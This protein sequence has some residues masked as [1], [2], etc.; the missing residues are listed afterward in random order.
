MAF[1]KKL[2]LLDAYA[3]IFRAYYA[4]INRPIMNSKGLN[5]SAIFGFV[6][7]LDEVLRKEKPTHIA[8]AFDPPSPTFRHHMYN[9]Y[10]ANRLE[11][12]ED[13]KLAVPY[14]KKILQAYNIAILEVEGY[15]ADD[16]IGTVSKTAHADGFTVFMMTPDK[17][18]AQLVSDGIYMF[19]PRHSGNDNEIWGPAE[20]KKNFEVD[21]PEQVIDIL[22]LWGD[23]A[24]NIPG[25]P[26]IGEK[27]SKKLIAE[28]GSIENLLA[29]SARLKG[30]QKESI[31]QN[32]EQIKLS[33]ELATIDIHVPV[34]L[35]V[36]EL[37]VKE[38]NKELLKIIFNEL[39]FK[40][41]AKRIIGEDVVNQSHT[42]G[43]LFDL[44]V[45]PIKSEETAEQTYKTFNPENV[46][47]IL[48]DNEISLNNLL[49]QLNKQTAF[50][51]DT[52]TTGLKVLEDSIVGLSVCFKEKEAY[53]I[54]FT[55][56]YNASINTLAKFSKVFENE[57]I[58]KIGHNL[59][60]DCQVLNKYGIRVNGE[61]FDTMVAHYLLQPERKHKLDTLTEELL[62][63]KMI[64]IEELIGKK[65]VDQLN[66]SQID[67]N[68]VK[69]YASEDADFTFRLYNLLKKEIQDKD[70][71]RLASEIEMPLI[72]VLTDV[73][74][75]GFNI[76]T[77]ALQDY[78]VELGNEIS[79]IEQEI[80]SLA[81]ENFNIA[82]PKQLGVILFE[83]LKI[84]S[85][86]KMTK[87]KQYSTG[88]EILVR[89][90]NEHPIINQILD[91]RTL[92]KL[93]STYV[94]V[95]PKLID[96]NSGR[97]HT[98]FNQTIAATG[99]LSSINP[100][101]QNIPIRDDRG[102]EI[103]KSFIPK[104]KD[105][106]L[107]SADYSQ[108]ELRLMAHMSG[109]PDMI[110]AFSKGEDIHRSTAAKIYKIRNDDVTREM[111]SK[112]KTA[113]FGIIYGISAFGLSQRLNIPRSEAKELIDNYFINF[114]MVRQYM[115]K[116]IEE[117]KLKGYV[118]TLFGRRRYLPDINSSNSLVRGV[119]ER[120][121]INS[122]LQGSAADIIKLAMIRIHEKI[123]F[124]FKT[125]MILQVHDE[126]VFDVL[127]TELETI[128][129]LVKFEMEN[130]VKL[131]VPLEVEIGIGKNW[132]EAH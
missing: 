33:K 1:E 45:V 123:K 124:N 110:D 36:D 85:D 67:I 61:F 60:F 92:T 130:V 16:V 98:S 90:K 71:N 102:R 40:T 111:R 118:S 74:L 37:K 4:F 17:D 28:F 122:P 112:A 65:G 115:D 62:G 58:I 93:Q 44:P 132:L 96:K 82:S 7:S 129:E 119:A 13:I 30:K 72:K 2:F 87:T 24:D 46:N 19:K 56:N 95:L 10:K 117:A 84:S 3:L 29:N 35:K 66:M 6:S 99:R 68:V 50:C 108:I 11:T 75:A 5:T 63:Y 76:D 89:L 104:G 109:D 57:N 69:D 22:A 114:P 100:N 97:I 34:N 55:L 23:A 51:F 88:E 48:I 38:P 103:R 31:E 15:E 39:E 21:R 9:A 64:S 125:Q 106:I 127:F 43:S 86:T 54:P 42:Q 77:E 131:S 80:Y 70:L 12:P 116:C 94:S 126:L 41:L 47:Y 128:E 73:E 91:Y 25:A 105:N 78:E 14:I 49:E 8:V 26:G 120:N 32:S 53:Y 121:A 113:N 83:K 101:L 107:L 79:K 20:V 81:G 59:K 52:E 18:Y 27:T